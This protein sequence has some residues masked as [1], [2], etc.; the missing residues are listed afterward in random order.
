[1]KSKLV[2]LALEKDMFNKSI[3]AL[4]LVLTAF[5]AAC[6]LDNP[7]APDPS[8][9]STLGRSIEVLA[10]PDQLTADGFSYSIIEAVL[11]GPN[12]ERIPGVTIHFDIRGFVDLG[13]LTPV[14]ELRRPGLPGV[15]ARAVEAVTASDGVAR[16]KYWAP[17][18]S[19]AADDIV[20]IIAREAGTNFR[21]ALGT[22]GEAEIFLRAADRPFPSPIPTPQPGCDP[23]SA[24]LAISGLCSGG[25][26]RVGSTI[27]VTGAAS[28]AGEEGASIS[29]YIFDWGDGATTQS[30]S[31][32]AS[33]V[34]NSSL[35]G[36]STTITLT[37]INSCGANA[38]T[39]ETGIL[40]VGACP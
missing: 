21:Q 18:R 9:P 25:E 39:S 34:Y 23:P 6:D 4:T 2:S 14:D 5:A 8:G 20:T 33:H 3:W 19:E 7:D 16:A 37:V 35:S 1:M 11:R 10:Q 38:S 28:E 30:G 26:I 36:L 17:F 27:R 31:V 13:N 29:T 24:D 40:V 32:T 22:V 15:E 12:G